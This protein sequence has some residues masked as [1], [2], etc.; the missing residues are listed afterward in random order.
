MA[1]IST[2]WTKDLGIGFRDFHI[3]V[4]REVLALE[5]RQGFDKN[6][7]TIVDRRFDVPIE[8]VKQFGIIEYAAR[9]DLRELLI[10][11]LA[12]LEK[13]SPVLTGRYRRSHLVFVN[14]TS[15][16]DIPINPDPDATYEFIN[17]QP[18][19]RRI[20]GGAAVR[21]RRSR[22]GTKSVTMAK[23]FRGWSKQ[24]PNG[25][26]RLVWREAQTRYGKVAFIEFRWRALEGGGTVMGFAGG[27]KNRQ[28]VRRDALY[29]S[30]RVRLSQGGRAQ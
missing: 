25:V 19:A 11:I 18:Y 21:I 1:D 15:I 30:I 10:D 26:Y 14:G 5:Q 8:N 6:P 28:R 12:R 24:A 4:S 16:E 23:G 27:G 2:T 17:V 9:A 13:R 7:R 3:Q 22:R 20:E 29:P